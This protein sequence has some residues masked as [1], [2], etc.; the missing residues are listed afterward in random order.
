LNLRKFILVFAVLL[1]AGCAAGCDLTGES[2]QVDPDLAGTAGEQL[3]EAI[4][5]TQATARAT[6]D[7]AYAERDDFI[8]QMGQELDGI[9]AE[10]D[11]ISLKVDRAG[12]VTRASAEAK[13]E[14]VRGRLALA[15]RRLAAAGT[16]TEADWD[17]VMAGFK[18]SYGELRN[19]FE[20]SRQW[21]SDAIEP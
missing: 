16:A 2:A 13:L 12:G 11:R 10:L 19:A 18:Q 5:Q 20:Q 3:D 6:Q 15:Q 14:A 1:A 9:E 8:D 7:F 17:V 4:A 21:L